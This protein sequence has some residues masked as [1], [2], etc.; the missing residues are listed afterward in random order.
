MNICAN[1]E[2]QSNVKKRLR[3]FK[4]YFTTVQHQNKKHDF[5]PNLSRYPYP[6]T[7]EFY[8][9]WIQK[10]LIYV[11]VDENS[12][13]HTWW[14]TIYLIHEVYLL[15]TLRSRRG[16][17]QNCSRA[18]Q[19]SPIRCKANFGLLRRRGHLTRGSRT[20]WS[21]VSRVNIIIFI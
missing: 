14:T 4:N 16:R 12:K 13:E 9:F 17:S 2:N 21:Q 5:L 10:L 20:T 18:R 1:Y 8:D 15:R 11:T 6:L 3:R 7:F 19:T